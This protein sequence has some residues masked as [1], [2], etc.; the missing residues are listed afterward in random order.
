MAKEGIFAI[1][2]AKKSD[3]EA[4]SKATGGRI[5][6]NIDDLSEEDLGN[7]SKVEEKKIGESDMV[8]VTAG[9]GGGTGTVSVGGGA[10]GDASGEAMG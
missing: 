2:R 6:T 9:E 8:F 7:A 4:L 1:R 10:I 3:M 5:V